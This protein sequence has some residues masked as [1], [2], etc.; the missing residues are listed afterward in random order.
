[1]YVCCKSRSKVCVL[2]V[3]QDRHAYGIEC[4]AI[5]RQAKEIVKE[6]GLEVK[7]FIFFDI[8]T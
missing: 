4:S 2:T 3:I 5:C 7:K 1:M 8:R 6:N